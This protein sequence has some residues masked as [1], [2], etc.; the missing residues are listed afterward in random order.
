MQARHAI[1]RVLLE[2]KVVSI[3]ET[4]DNVTIKLN[5]DKLLTEGVD[6]V[7]DF[8]HKISKI[9]ILFYSL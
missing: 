4:E 7:G 8:L 6:A 5:R 2:K 9:L 1:M 3:E